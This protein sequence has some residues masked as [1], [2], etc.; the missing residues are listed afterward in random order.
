MEPVGLPDFE[1]LAETVAAAIFIIQ[2]DRFRYVN[3]ATEA[4]TGYPTR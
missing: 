1:T 3:P 4:V 2:G